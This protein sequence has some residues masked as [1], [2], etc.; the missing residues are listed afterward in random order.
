MPL[1]GPPLLETLSSDLDAL[2]GE[3][4]EHDDVRTR[5][6][7]L[8]GL[9]LALDLDLDLEREPPRALGGGDSVP[10]A[11]PAPD[12]VVLE[13]DHGAQ[14]HAVAVGPADQHAVLLDEAEPGRGLARARQLA[15]VTRRPQVDEEAP[16]HAGD[17][18]AAREDV[19]GDALAQQDAPRGARDGGDLH[20]DAAPFLVALDVL[21]LA[22]VPLDGAARLGK[23]LVEEGHAGQ[24]AARLAP[25][26]G[27]ARGVAD[28]EAAVVEG[29]RVLGQPGGDL[30]LP[31]RRQE[32]LQ[33]AVVQR[34]V[35]HLG[36]WNGWWCSRCLGCDLVVDPWFMQDS[37]TAS[38]KS[39]VCAVALQMSGD[40]RN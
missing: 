9:G 21:A 33:R 5:L 40:D 10:D 37:H 27:G 1:A 29:R 35:P 4:V 16:R 19:E 7:G 17:A 6:D 15:A 24:D 11:A 20:L 38:C 2:A 31:G 32:V 22:G 23:D 14:V 28:D 26:G 13:H 39:S 36:W 18:A 34:H 12:V 3:V 30:R 8:V 25:E